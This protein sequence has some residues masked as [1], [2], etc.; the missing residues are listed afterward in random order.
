MKHALA[1]TKH[2]DRSL[3]PSNKTEDKGDG[4]IVSAS[5][6]R[7]MKA[8]PSEAKD[9]FLH[10]TK[11]RNSIQTNAHI[12]DRGKIK[13]AIHDPSNARNDVQQIA[14]AEISTDGVA[15]ETEDE[16]LYEYVFFPNIQRQ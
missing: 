3:S 5:N 13:E 4:I 10:A 15:V 6:V 7:D 16:D 11:E 2:S 9:T 1:Q 12:E 14:E 8:S